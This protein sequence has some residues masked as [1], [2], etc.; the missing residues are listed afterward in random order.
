M[1]RHYMLKKIKRIIEIIGIVTV[2][3]SFI[4]SFV[5]A[6]LNMFM[7]WMI[8]MGIAM[9]DGMALM[10]VLMVEDYLEI[11]KEMENNNNGKQ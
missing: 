3:V 2:V 11:E 7:L 4:T 10:V 6:M 1:G 8:P 9:I 5:A